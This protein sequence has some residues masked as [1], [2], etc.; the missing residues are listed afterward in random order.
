MLFPHLEDAHPVPGAGLEAGGEGVAAGDGGRRRVRVRDVDEHHLGEG[1]RL[2]R[3]AL[4]AVYRV[5]THR[6]GEE[7]GETSQG[8]IDEHR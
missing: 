7:D 1:A 6:G 2:V 5:K 3:G 4:H 8:L